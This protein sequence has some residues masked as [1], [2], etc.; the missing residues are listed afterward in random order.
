MPSEGGKATVRFG[1]SGVCL[2]SAVPNQGFTVSTEQS[3]PEKLTVTF[4]ASRHRSEVT[5]TT[6]PQ[7]QANVR[8]VSW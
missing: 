6:R 7:S 5:A 4:S 2:I 1:G 3:E 8:E